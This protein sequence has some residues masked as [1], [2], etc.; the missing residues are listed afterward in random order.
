MRFSISY[1][2]L[3]Y[4]RTHYQTLEAHI[5]NV[6]L[7]HHKNVH[8]QFTYIDILILTC[9]TVVASA[10]THFISLKTLTSVGLTLFLPFAQLHRKKKNLTA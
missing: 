9:E 4:K 2:N 7:R 10:V 1:Y 8:F 5:N 6:H 3:T